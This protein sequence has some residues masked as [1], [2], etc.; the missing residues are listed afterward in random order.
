[1][2]VDTLDIWY[3][4]ELIELQQVNLYDHGKIRLAE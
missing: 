4:E 1:M 2:H 3:L